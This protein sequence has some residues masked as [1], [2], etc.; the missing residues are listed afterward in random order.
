MEIV[1]VAVCDS[2]EFSGTIPRRPPPVANIPQI[3]SIQ[4]KSSIFVQNKWNVLK[5][6]LEFSKNSLLRHK[7]K[8]RELIGFF[9]CFG[10]AYKMSSSIHRS[11]AM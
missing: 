3:R 4:S 9:L 1:S 7:E 2:G 5:S 10:A 6:S 11:I 8:R